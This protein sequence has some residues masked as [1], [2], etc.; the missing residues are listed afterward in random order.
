VLKRWGTEAERAAP[1]RGDWWI[2]RHRLPRGS[3]RRW[4]HGG[5]L[6]QL[7]EQ[8]HRP[9]RLFQLGRLFVELHGV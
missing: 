3:I 6:S 8:L 5:Q 1:A 2:R 7:K 9:G 4:Q